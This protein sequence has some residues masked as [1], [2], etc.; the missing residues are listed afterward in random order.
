MTLDCPSECPYLQEARKH[1]KPRA[2]TEEQR[3]ELFPRVEVKQSFAYEREPLIVG[4]SYALVKS[5]REERSINDRDV[6]GAVVAL[7]RKYET[8]VGSGLVYQ[9]QS[10]NLLQQHMSDE[11]EK[12]IGEY[13]EMEQK[14]VGYA[15]LR[16]S[17]VLQALVFIV[18]MAYGK[19]SGRPRSRAFLEFLFQRFPQK[20]SGAAAPQGSSLI[21]P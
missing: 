9:Q 7:G 14:H 13:R 17:E 19:T 5:A 20:E 18:R 21:I 2:L 1:E 16:D 4:L 3:A 15:T 10:A 11:M 12:M 6:L 8:M